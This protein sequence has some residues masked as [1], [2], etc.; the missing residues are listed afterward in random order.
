MRD[1]LYE[2][3]GFS[4]SGA[5]NHQE[6]PVDV[7]DCLLLL[8]IRLECGSATSDSHCAAEYQNS[9]WSTSPI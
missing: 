3:S 9:Y 7:L 2:D 4:R 6:W 1:A 5:G 8:R